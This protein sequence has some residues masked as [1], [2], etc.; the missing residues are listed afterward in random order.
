MLVNRSSVAIYLKRNLL[1]IQ[2]EMRAKEKEK[3]EGD[4]DFHR[5]HNPNSI[6]ESSMRPNNNR[7]VSQ[8]LSNIFKTASIDKEGGVALIGLFYFFFILDFQHLIL[9]LFH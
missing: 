3:I 5:C 7:R 8:L 6:L 1:S 9:F 4:N 2:I